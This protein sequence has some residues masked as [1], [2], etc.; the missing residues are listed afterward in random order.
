MPTRST[1]NLDEHTV[2]KICLNN[3]GSPL[4]STQ[5]KEA[6]YSQRAKKYCSTMIYRDSDSKKP[7]EVKD[8]FYFPISFL[9]H[10]ERA[11]KEKD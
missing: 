2:K 8:I 9:T 10:L 4:E 6:T 7:K 1:K 11:W 5:L 3:R